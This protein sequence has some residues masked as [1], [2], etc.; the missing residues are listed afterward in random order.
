MIASDFTDTGAFE[1]KLTSDCGLVIKY[2]GFF[3]IEFDEAHVFLLL[4]RTSI[5]Q[6]FLLLNV[7]G[8][9]LIQVV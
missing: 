3:Q 2:L 9:I 1:A 4:F 7:F 6:Q 5:V 8:S